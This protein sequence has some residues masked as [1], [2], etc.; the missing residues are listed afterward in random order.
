MLVEWNEGNSL[1]MICA[2][3]GMSV[4]A[5]ETLCYVRGECAHDS[6]RL[7]EKLISGPRRIPARGD[8]SNCWVDGKKLVELVAPA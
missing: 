8:H 1:R 5:I 4:L 3:P 2:I 6:K 7:F